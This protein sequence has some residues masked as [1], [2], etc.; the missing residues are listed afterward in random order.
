M[1]RK[2][3]YP[4]ESLI[5]LSSLP[6]FLMLFI[7][8]EIN[9][10]KI[11]Q[12]MI[13]DG[14]VLAKC[15]ISLINREEIGYAN[16]LKKFKEYSN[17]F[18]SRDSNNECYLYATF[19]SKMDNEIFG[20]YKYH[21]DS[22]YRNSIQNKNDQKKIVKVYALSFF[23]RPFDALEVN[24]RNKIEEIIDLQNLI[25]DKYLFIL[26]QNRN[27]DRFSQKKIVDSL[28]LEINSNY[29]R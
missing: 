12:Q 11:N 27:E 4:Q 8:C 25:D 28:I 9:S 13:N 24:R 1:E 22:L 7:S 15:P 17:E 6:L 19:V 16:S 18:I 10:N 5:W 23:N 20:N 2:K 29:F 3:N 14:E 21:L 26:Y